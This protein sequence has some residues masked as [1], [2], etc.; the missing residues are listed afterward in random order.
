MF[1]E[2]SDII[3]SNQTEPY[4]YVKEIAN[5]P[6]YRKIKI[7]LGK[8]NLIAFIVLLVAQIILMIVGLFLFGHLVHL[9]ILFSVMEVPLIILFLLMPSN[10]ICIFDYNA[11]TFRSYPVGIIPV[12]CKCFSNIFINFCDISG[13]FVKKFIKQGKRHCK[14]GVKLNDGQELAIIVGQIVKCGYQDSQEVEPLNYSPYILRKFLKAGE[15][16]IL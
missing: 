9:K 4:P 10:A 6:E 7:K 16:N 15:H 3:L 5:S 8:A 13:F 2:N 1:E 12:P 11:K 14:V